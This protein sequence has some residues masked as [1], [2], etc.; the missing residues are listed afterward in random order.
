MGQC[1]NTSKGATKV[2]ISLCERC[3]IT[4]HSSSNKQMPSEAHCTRLPS[5][6]ELS[7]HCPSTSCEIKIFAGALAFGFIYREVMILLLFGFVLYVLVV[8]VF[9]CLFECL[10]VCSVP[11]VDVTGVAGVMLMLYFSFRGPNAIH[12]LLLFY[13]LIFLRLLLLYKKTKI[14]KRSLMALGQTKK[15]CINIG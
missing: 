9:V 5:C 1:T 14:A 15:T 4:K 2:C 8:C 7:P 10:F 13:S 6:L 12:F 3:A 11:F